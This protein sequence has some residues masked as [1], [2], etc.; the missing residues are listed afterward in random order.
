MRRI[1]GARCSR[2]RTMPRAGHVV[3]DLS[4]RVCA[5]IQCQGPIRW[6][7][8]WRR[9]DAP[10]I[11]PLLTPSAVYARRFITS[12]RETV[13]FR[14]TAERRCLALNPMDGS[15]IAYLG[16][17][18]ATTGEWDRGAAHGGCRHETRPAILAGS[19]SPSG[20]TPI[21][22]GKYEEALE[23]ITRVN[24]PGYFHAQAARAATLGKLGRK[25]EAQKALPGFAG[26]AS[27]F[28]FPWRDGNMYD[29]TTPS[30]SN[31]SS[32]ACAKLEWS[33]RESRRRAATVDSAAG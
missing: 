30:T 23:A 28:R 31:R 13:A 18:T 16:M 6:I 2:S 22:K 19:R 7:G 29:G 33:V 25:E 8:L 5:G 12:A 14:T 20:Q 4:W 10:W 11:S 15:A 32:T 1:P 26:A 27:R 17:L 3:D 24:L 9:H 21:T